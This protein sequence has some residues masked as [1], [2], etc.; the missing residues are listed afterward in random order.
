MKW[1]IEPLPRPYDTRS[2]IEVYV[3][4]R[5]EWY[6]HDDF[7]NYYT[8]LLSALEKQFGLRLSRDELKTSTQK[9]LWM[10]FESTTASILSICTPWDGFIEDG[11]LH[12]KLEQSGEY[13]KAVYAASG[14]IYKAA[15]ESLRGHRDMLQALFQA[16]FGPGPMER[17][18]TSAELAAAGFDDSK[19][20]PFSAYYDDM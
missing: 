2:L 13:G 14:V 6:S 20:P 17:V 5:Q 9:A 12:T 19:E 15:E 10:L 18:V 1:Y 7:R 4:T 8:G 11:L 16:I 3:R